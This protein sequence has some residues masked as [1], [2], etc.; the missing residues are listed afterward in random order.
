MTKKVW[1]I[2]RDYLTAANNR[3]GNFEIEQARI[4]AKAGLDVTFLS[5]D[6]RS[7]RRRRPLGYVTRMEEGVRVATASFPIGGLVPRSVLK[8][9]RYFQFGRLMKRLEKRNGRPDIIHAHYMSLLPYSILVPWQDKGVKIVGT[10]HWSRV[11]GQ[12]LEGELKENLQQYTDKADA[13][14]CVSESLEKSVRDLTGTKRQI[15]IIPNVLYGDFSPKSEPHEGFRFVSIGRM[16]QIKQYDILVRA[17]L[18]TF[19]DHPEVTLTM[20]GDGTEFEK[21]AGIVRDAGA[22]DQVILTGQLPHEEIAGLIDSCD[23]FIGFSWLETFCVPVVEA[24]SCGKPVITSST[25]GVF[26][27]HPDE[28][29]G[30]MVP[31]DA[32]GQLMVAMEK[33]VREYDRYDPV[34]ISEY[35][36]TQFSEKVF[37]D[38]TLALYDEL[39]QPTG[40]CS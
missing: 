6:M 26:A 5:T 14:C 32:P 12:A 21:I 9:F 22:E 25:T 34:W 11:Q 29:L 37:L 36:D 35:A 40:G 18:E 39:C 28:R 4:L 20:A 8:K 16:V 1:I 38:K 30:L 27:D 7:V 31:P 3:M 24:W 13:V 15:R 10:E 2:G 33:M 17:F 19:K 23:A